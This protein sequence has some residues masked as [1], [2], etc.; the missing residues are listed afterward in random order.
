MTPAC[1]WDVSDVLRVLGER[2]R[3]LDGMTDVE[4][5]SPF[6][7]VLTFETSDQAAAVGAELGSDRTAAPMRAA[8]ELLEVKDR[9]VHVRFPEI[10]EMRVTA[11]GG[12]H[13]TACILHTEGS[14]SDR[15]PA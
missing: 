4:R 7:G 12:D 13:H 11:V 3:L 8:Q 1:G 5:R 10:D 15:S 6:E 2:G 14:A 9:T